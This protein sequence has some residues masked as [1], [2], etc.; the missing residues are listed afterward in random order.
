MN[1]LVSPLSEMTIRACLLRS[2]ARF[3]AKKIRMWEKKL[4]PKPGGIKISLESVTFGSLQ[5]L[6]TW[7]PWTTRE[8]MDE[9]VL[10]SS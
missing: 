7:C 8:Y 3:D 5:R 10:G 9:W 1:I 4:R 2:Y 6:L